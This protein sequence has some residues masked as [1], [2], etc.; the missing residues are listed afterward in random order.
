MNAGAGLDDLLDGMTHDTL[1]ITG[2]ERTCVVLVDAA[3]ASQ[4]RVATSASSQDEIVD[5]EDLSQTVIQR[6]LE[7]QTPLLLH[8][9]FDDQELMGRPS[10]TDLSLRSI[11]C[12]P[13]LRSDTLY[14]VMYADSASAAGSFDQ[15]DLEVLSL[16][17]EQ[18]AG[19]LET[20]R[21]VADVQ[22]SMDELKAMQERLV[23]GERLRTMGE[24][25]SGVAH[26]FN[27]LLTS[28]LARVQLI[29]LTPVGPEL[30]QDLDLIEKAC[31]DA[32]QVVRRLQNF[33]RHQRQ[34]HF[35]RL[36]LAEICRDAVEFLRPLW[37]TRRRHGR[38]PVHVQLHVE[39]GM[40]VNGDPTEL[41]E[42]VTNLL[43]NA[44]D[45]LTDGGEI[46]IAAHVVS[47]VILL[48][49]LDDGPGMPPEIQAHIFD[50]FFTTK[51]ERGT[52]LGLCL[53]Q[54][55]VERHGGEITVE[56]APGEGTAFHIE[57][58]AAGAVVQ[59]S[60][61]PE[62]KPE[63]D[64]VKMRV[65]VVDDDANV[66]E[67]L[68]RY[69]EQSGYDVC[70]AANGRAG[71]EAVTQHNPNVVITDV[72][73]PEMDGL[74]LCE[75]LRRESSDLPI[76]IMSGWAKG[77]DATRARRAGATAMLGKPFALRQVTELLSSVGDERRQSSS[78]RA[79]TSGD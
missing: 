69:L 44:L 10:I 1:E 6:V 55:I 65:L 24:L 7:S 43:K 59:L 28:I 9:V 32:A 35:V 21:L 2:A 63:E 57:L 64:G 11:L 14:G 17:A 48:R 49:V 70:A 36:D 53:S 52:G 51:G 66:R 12:V 76:M 33:T 42:V 72:A 26:E 68:V 54:Q 45:A 13:M 37:S 73:M 8:D 62:E 40:M 27:N 20:H 22:N 41:R 19:A 74:E 34:G 61:D 58:P 60:G 78:K 47:G 25:S 29:N 38:A 30:K 50:P 46:T 23:K 79:T 71:L 15:V 56:S 16:F 67:P 39:E 77:V 18:A 5:V 4:V 31:L 75:R 3:A